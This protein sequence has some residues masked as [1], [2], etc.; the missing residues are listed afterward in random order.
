[1]ENKSPYLQFPR[2]KGRIILCIMDGNL[3]LSSSSIDKILT[4]SDA[5]GYIFVN[6]FS[7]SWLNFVS[8]ITSMCFSSYAL[9]NW[10]DFD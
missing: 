5:L 7:L 8:E 10:L 3:V 6:L 4:Q 1:M 9:N 2:F